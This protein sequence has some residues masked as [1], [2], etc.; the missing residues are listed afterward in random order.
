MTQGRT[1]FVDTD[2]QSKSIFALLKNH[3]FNYIRLKTF[4]EPTAVTWN[5]CTGSTSGDKA[6]V[7]EYGAQVKAAQMGFLLDFHYSD[8]WADPGNQIIPLPWRG[9]LQRRSLPHWWRSTPMMS[10]RQRSPPGR[11]PTWCRSAMR[12]LTEC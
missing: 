6:H 4:V 10:S 2:G 7:I 12:S 9:L 5:G 11:A 1:S 8:V 3:G